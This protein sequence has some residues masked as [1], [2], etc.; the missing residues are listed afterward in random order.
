MKNYLIITLIIFSAAYI[1]LFVGWP[2]NL[3]DSG[4]VIRCFKDRYH[5]YRIDESFINPMHEKKGLKWPGFGYKASEPLADA[6]LRVACSKGLPSTISDQEVLLTQ[7]RV[8]MENNR[9]PLT[10][11]NRTPNYDIFYHPGTYDFIP[12][13]KATAKLLFLAFVDIII[14]LWFKK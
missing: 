1:Y 7:I 2:A 11:L 8:D 13:S 6:F 3:N 4:F 14:F 9:L 10:Y 12:D 5:S